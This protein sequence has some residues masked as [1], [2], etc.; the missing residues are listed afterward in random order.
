MVFSA[1]SDTLKFISAF[2][3]RRGQSSS[4]LEG[5]VRWGGVPQSQPAEKPPPTA[6]QTDVPPFP[7]SVLPT[8][9]GIH[10]LSAPPELDS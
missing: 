8:Q 3:V 2:S 10:R 1:H 5:E 7:L 4:P 9:E 6:P